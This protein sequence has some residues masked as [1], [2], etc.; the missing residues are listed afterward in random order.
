MQKTF[1]ERV[2][3][4]VYTGLSF[5]Q[6]WKPLMKTLEKDSLERLS[7]SVLSFTRR[8]KPLERLASSVLSFTRRFK[9]LESNPLDV[10][11]I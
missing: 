4:I 3:G 5:I 10:G 9:P 6:R 1:P 11:F 8:F 2:I 7:S